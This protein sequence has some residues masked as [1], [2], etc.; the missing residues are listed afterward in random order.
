MQN[1]LNKENVVEF[2]ASNKS[3]VTTDVIKGT[4]T[5]NKEFVS[6]INQL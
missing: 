5:P 1:S 6:Q 2:T 3:G 4:G